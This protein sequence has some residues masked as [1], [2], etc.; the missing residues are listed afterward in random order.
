[1]IARI[2]KWFQAAVPNP[3]TENAVVQI[4]CHF[5]ECAEMAESLGD[6]V[7]YAELDWAAADY[8]ARLDWC[9][10]AVRGMDGTARTA[11]LDALCDQIVTAVGVGHMLGFDMVGALTEV[12]LSN[13]SKF[14]DGRPVFDENGKIRKG[15]DYFAPDL[16]DFAMPQDAAGEGK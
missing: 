10:E 9:M 1:M 6:E 3:Q 12:M 14:E 16:A 2:V 4:G 13:E 15:R 7:L 8:K 11:L 5:E